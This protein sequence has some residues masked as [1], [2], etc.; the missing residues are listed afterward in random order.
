MK[1]VSSKSLNDDELA[2]LDNLL[3]EYANEE[4][5]EGIFTL[6]ELDG[7]LTAIIS[8]PMLI[9]PST[10]IPA[11]WDN[12]LPEW[13]NEQEMAMFFDLLFRHYNSIIMMLQTGLE[14]YSPCFEYSNFTD[15]DYPIVD[16]WC[17]G[18]MRGVKLADWQN[19][20]TKLQP[21][22]KLIEAQTHL[23]S[24]LDDYVSPSLQEQNELADRLIE[25][26]VEIY[27]YFR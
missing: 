23:H 14:Y 21:Y 26:A 1:E 7:Y 24:S 2:L 17:F 16:D 8:S 27:R 9:Q 3:L 13:E 18:Y 5:D 6:S 12:D 25:A 10:W 11:I 19:L 22:L 20:P 15:G 4:S